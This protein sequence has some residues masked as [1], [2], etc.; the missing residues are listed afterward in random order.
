MTE[1]STH[2]DIW[3]LYNNIG[4]G[5]IA[6]SSVMEHMPKITLTNALLILPLITHTPT[7]SYL[8]R[9]TTNIPS[10]SSLLI[11][12]PELFINFNDRFYNALPLSINTIQFIIKNNLGNLEDNFLYSERKI[13]INN[14][15]GKR[16]KKIFLASNNIAKLL[17]ESDK[18]LYL[19]FRVQL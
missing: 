16:A 6:L 8:S 5:V 4:I 15:Y 9:K 11:S 18:E 2:H 19:N 13:E 17:I 7:L 12:H 3:K 14:K 10:S 1:H